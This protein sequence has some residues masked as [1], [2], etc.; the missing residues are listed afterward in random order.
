MRRTASF[1]LLFCLLY[2]L[3]A[4]AQQEKDYH[5]QQFTTDNGL[6]SNGVKSMQ[7]DEANGFLW[8]ATEAGMSRY[9]GLDFTNYTKENTPGLS[10]ER[11]AFVVKNNTGTIIA[12]DVSGNLVRVNANSLLPNPDTVKVGGFKRRY[13]VNATGSQVLDKVLQ[14]IRETGNDPWDRLFIDADSAVLI[15]DTCESIPKPF[16]NRLASGYC[17]LFVGF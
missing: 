2:C 13:Y 8:I 12:A 17:T 7:W 10:H 14:L 4:N 9:N 6:P 16:R 1:T 5:I 15:V 11:M 3:S